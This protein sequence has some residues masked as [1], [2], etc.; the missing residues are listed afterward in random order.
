V[1]DFENQVGPT[2]TEAQ[3]FRQEGHPEL[4]CYSAPIKSSSKIWWSGKQHATSNPAIS[5][6]KKKYIYEFK[7][8]RSLSNKKKLVK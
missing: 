3:W 8:S 6:E 5:D 7:P 1:W 2:L 4:K